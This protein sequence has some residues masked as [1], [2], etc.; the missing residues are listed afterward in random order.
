MY[1]L[2]ATC[3]RSAVSGEV[4]LNRLVRLRTRLMAVERRACVKLYYCRNSCITI[5]TG[6][7]V[8]L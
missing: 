4:G 2:Q 7:C 3:L 1:R 6:R 8:K 5:L